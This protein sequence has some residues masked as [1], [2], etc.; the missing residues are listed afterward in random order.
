[1]SWKPTIGKWNDEK[2]YQ[3]KEPLW[4]SMLKVAAKHSDITELQELLLWLHNKNMQ[5]DSFRMGIIGY[6]LCKIEVDL[7]SELS[8][9][10]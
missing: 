7:E 5:G 2:D 4:K 1:M 3:M 10:N 9:S 6:H 8:F